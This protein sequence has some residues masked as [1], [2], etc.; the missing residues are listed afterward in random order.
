VPQSPET[1]FTPVP[2]YNPAAAPPPAPQQIKVPPPE[3][4]PLRAALRV[5]ATLPP[6]PPPLQEEPVNNPPPEVHPLAAANRPGSTLPA[7]GPQFYTYEVASYLPDFLNNPPPPNLQPPNTFALGQRPQRLLPI[8]AEPDPYAALG[9]RAGSFI[10]LPSPT[11]RAPPAPI[12]NAHG[13]V[14]RPLMLS[15]RRN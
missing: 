10:L 13:A 9:I 3:V 6:P 14:R 7:P 8:L 1:T 5:G 4:Y 12:P 11:F 15:P 2:T